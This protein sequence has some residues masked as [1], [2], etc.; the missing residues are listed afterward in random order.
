MLE[1][2]FVTDL[3]SLFT[4]HKMS[5]RPI[6]AK[7]KHF[8]TIC[9]QTSD[10]SPTDSNSSFRTTRMRHFVKLLNFLVFHF[11]VSL[12]AFFGR[13][14]QCRRTTLPFVREVSAIQVIFLFLQ[15]KYVTRTFSDNVQKWFQIFCI[16]AE[17][18]HVVKQ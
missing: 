12:N 8:K 9:E 4:D 18:I 16:H 1:S 3:A 5:S 13:A 7:Y 15:E 14:H 17:Y 6:L 11:T 10:N 2:I